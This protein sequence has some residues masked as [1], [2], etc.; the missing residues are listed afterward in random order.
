[1]RILSGGN[2]G[3]GTTTP[4]SMLHVNSSAGIGAL[5]IQNT[6]TAGLLFVNA[7]SGFTG[8]GTT[9]PTQALDVANGNIN[10]SSLG[11][12]IS[13]GGGRIYWDNPNSRLVIKVS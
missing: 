1:M 12:N 11:G 8:I 13:L 10:I 5:H 2:V 3:I 6:T 4:T 7:S 9:T